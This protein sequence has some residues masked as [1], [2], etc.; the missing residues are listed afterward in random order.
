M[1]IGWLDVVRFADTIGYHSDNPRNIWPY[2]DWV[3]KSFNDNKPFDRFTVEQVAGD[4]LARRE[5]RNAHRFGVQPAAALHRG[6]RR[7]GQGLRGAHAH[8]PRAGR[9]GGLA[10]A[11]PPGA[12]SATTTS[13]TP[14]RCATFTRWAPSSRTSRSQSSAIARKVWPSPRRTT[15]DHGHTRRGAGGGQVAARRRH[16]ATGR[17]GGSVGGRHRP[18]RRSGCPSWWRTPGHPTSSRETARSVTEALKKPA[19][20]RA[21]EDANRSEPTSCRRRQRYSMPSAMRSPRPSASAR[22][23]HDSLPKCLVSVSSP[24]RRTVRIL[25]RGNWMDESGEIVK[26][27][28]PA[29]PAAP[30]REEREL[31]RLDL[32]RWLVVA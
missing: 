18:L 30:G 19:A 1:A 15:E 17:R 25:P 32:A 26:P 2:R 29:L 7:P 27:A 3:I 14:S 23:S 11:R 9:R 8:R 21:A 20:S 28:L 24:T 13:S 12:A 16:S 22:R 4:L 5:R 31:T 6:R 10:R